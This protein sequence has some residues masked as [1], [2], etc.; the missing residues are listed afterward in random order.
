M[1]MAARGLLTSWATPLA[2]SPTVASFSRA[3]SS[4]CARSSSV[5]SYSATRMSSD[6]NPDRT[7]T[8]Q[9]HSRCPPA[10]WTIATRPCHGTVRLRS[11]TSANATS[12]DDSPRVSIGCPTTDASGASPNTSRPA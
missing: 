4:R 8:V 7:V 9:S 1:R 2:I 11:R 3:I 6:P 10:G 5:R 12:L